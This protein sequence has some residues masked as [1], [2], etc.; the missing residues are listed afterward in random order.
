MLF[1]Q[2][3][4]SPW[5][6]PVSPTNHDRS[7][8]SALL[9]QAFEDPEPLL[10]NPSKALSPLSSP[11]V[12]YS[13]VAPAMQGPSSSGGSSSWRGGGGS[14]GEWSAQ[15]P[16]T[17]TAHTYYSYLEHPDDDIIEEDKWDGFS[18]TLPRSSVAPLLFRMIVANCILFYGQQLSPMLATIGSIVGS[19]GKY[20]L[21][22]LQPNT[23][24]G[25]LTNFFFFGTLCVYHFILLVFTT[26]S[27]LNN[28]TFHCFQLHSIFSSLFDLFG[29]FKEMIS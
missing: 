6:H 24:P 12:M 16:G 21:T 8:T 13:P 29:F 23:F 17:S 11:S 10:V 7:T 28:N 25:L 22:L 15:Q 14:G 26:R 1:V 19:Q 20:T 2:S 4:D 27:I 3:E 9:S 5:S 18:M